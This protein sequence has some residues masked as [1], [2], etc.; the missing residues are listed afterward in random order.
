M[1]SM[2]KIGGRDIRLNGWVPRIAR[3]EGEKYCFLDEQ[4]PAL[5]SESL[6]KCGERIDLFTFVQKV[7]EPSPK[8]TYPWEWDNFAALPITTFDQWWTGQIKDKTRNLVRKAQKKGVTLREIPLDES[9]VRGI[10]T[11]YNECPIRQGKLFPH[12]GM[13][14]ERV[15]EYAGTF[16]DRSIF[17]GA[18]L[19][20]S[21]IGFAKLTIDETQTQAGLMHILSMLQHRDKASTNALIAEAVR[22]CSKRNIPYLIYS[23]FAYGNKQSDGLSGFKEHNGFQRI[24]VP[25]YY[26]PLTWL[27]RIAYRF[28][29]HHRFAERLPET[30]ITRFREFRS[31]WYA[32]K[33]QFFPKVK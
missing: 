12:Y 28:G 27:G 25:R 14:L 19:D 6:R 30:W 8:Y 5:F 22:S 13:S 1:A 2:L 7:T 10:W 21:L 15:H 33:M 20:D 26:V 24:D 17:I 18:F 23:N 9:L 32:R 4:E 29:M 16:L 31:S 3:I 11:I